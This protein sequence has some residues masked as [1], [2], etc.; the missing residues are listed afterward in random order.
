MNR[1]IP[2]KENLNKLLPKLVRTGFFHIFGA[3]AI[4]KIIGFAS[5][6]ILVRIL[7]KADYGVYTYANNIFS[8]CLLF[9]GLGMTSAVLQLCSETQDEGHRLRIYQFGTRIGVLFNLGLALVILGIGFFVPLPIEGSNQLLLLMCCLPIFTLITELQMLYLRV[10]LKNKEFARLNTFNSIVVMSLSCTFAYFLEAPGLVLA[11]YAAKI[12]TSVFAQRRFEAPISFKKCKLSREEGKALFFISSFSLLSNGFGR[13]M[14]IVDI[15]ILGVVISDQTVVATYKIATIIP[16][17][18]QFIPAAAMIYVYPYFARNHRNKKWLIGTFNK[19]IFAFGGFNIIISA[20]MVLLANPIINI[21]FGTQYLEAIPAFRILS[22][23]YFFT[24]TFRV[25]AGNL[26]VT[27]RKLKFNLIISILSSGMN[28]M[29]NIFMIK[30]WGLNGAAIATLV[31]GMA[32][33]FVST[34]Y[35]LRTFQ[36]IK[37]NDNGGSDENTYSW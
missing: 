28:I 10:N 9:T 37:A 17:A 15:F 27:Q 4:N 35:I 1:I 31:T 5:G 34:F 33:G 3:S 7:S 18:L 2:L 32:T 6:L 24:S 29:L 8:F 11:G 12:V 26:L 22:I 25:V 23:S 30:E 16:S 21:F 36:K 14:Y 20:I 13:L 19:L